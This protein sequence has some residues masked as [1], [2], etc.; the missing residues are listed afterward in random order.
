MFYLAGDNNLDPFLRQSIQKLTEQVQSTDVR[1]IVLFDGARPNDSRL[2]EISNGLDASSTYEIIQVLMFLCKEQQN[3]I[4]K[5]EAER[6]HPS[7]LRSPSV[8]FR[9]PRLST[10]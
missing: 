6:N 4:E 3:R 5:K 1:I 10:T 7:T 9:L 2:I 8:R